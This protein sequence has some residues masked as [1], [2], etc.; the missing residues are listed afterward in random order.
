VTNISTHYKNYTNYV[1]RYATCDFL[2]EWSAK[3]TNDMR[4]GPSPEKT[5]YP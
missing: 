2:N 1:V 3:K 5:G 4:C